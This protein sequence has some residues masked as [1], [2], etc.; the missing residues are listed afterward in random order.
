VRP[1]TPRTPPGTPSGSAVIAAIAF[2][3]MDTVVRDP[4]REA[5]EAATGRP[6]A[7][8][9]RR[10]SRAVYPALERGE[11]SEEEYW[12]AYAAAGIEVDPDTF[13][14]VRRAGTRWLPGMRELLADLDGVVLRATASNYP[15]WIEELATGMLTGCFERVLASCHLGAR[16]PDP[17]F[18][19]A[20][21][22]ALE[23]PAPAVLFVD[24][25]EENVAAARAAGL[26]AHRFQGV[27]ELRAW[28][29]GHGVA[30]PEAAA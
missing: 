18:F 7:E 29:V 10:R 14:R 17:T 27:D 6:I 22:A 28:L 25:R 8:L 19:D 9:F 1:S 21:L 30:L 4:Y 2:D 15:H 13:H 5:L 26:A 23:L 24:D 11:L 12:A 16:K 3:L 20:L